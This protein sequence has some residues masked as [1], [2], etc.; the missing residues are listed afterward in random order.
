[1]AASFILLV[2][3]AG[4]MFVVPPLQVAVSVA[5]ILTVLYFFWGHYRVYDHLEQRLGALNIAFANYQRK[6]SRWRGAWWRW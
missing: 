3:L 1:M 2:L 6:V 5:S 4:V